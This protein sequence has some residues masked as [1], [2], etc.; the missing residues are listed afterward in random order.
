[1]HY[2]YDRSF[3]R[4]QMTCR[5]RIRTLIQCI[6][7]MIHLTL[8]NNEKLASNFPQCFYAILYASHPL[9]FVQNFTE[10]VSGELLRRE[11]NARWVAKYSDVGHVEGYLGN[12]LGYN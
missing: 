10:I 7:E 9:T 11:L 3:I 12:G 8:T 2:A 1:M 4:M 5:P 6:R